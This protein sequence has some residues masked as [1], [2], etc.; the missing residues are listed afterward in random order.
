MALYGF[1]GQILL[2]ELPP[3]RSTLL[4]AQHKQEI[5]RVQMQDLCCGNVLLKDP[6]VFQALTHRRRESCA[7]HKLMA[8]A[9]FESG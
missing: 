4:Y 2:T 8:G 5:A 1:N 7:L 9:I 3:L 6:A